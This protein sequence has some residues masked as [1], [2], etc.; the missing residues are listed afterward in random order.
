MENSM[1]TVQHSSLYNLVYFFLK[2]IHN[3]FHAEDQAG[4]TLSLVFS[5]T[6]CI[7]ILPT[8]KPD[9]YIS[10]PKYVFYLLTI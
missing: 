2:V 3:K 8:W 5:I 6:F 4:N 7:E 1:V 9:T 10:L